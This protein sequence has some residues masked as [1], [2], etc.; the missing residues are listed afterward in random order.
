MMKTSRSLQ[1]WVLF[2]LLIIVPA[3]ASAHTINL[4]IEPKTGWQLWW[5]F[6]GTGYKHIL[7]LGLDHILFITCLFFIA[8]SHKQLIAYSLIFTLA[9]SI[10]LGLAVIQFIPQQ[11][12]FVEP[13][14]ALSIVMMAL[15]AL[16]PQ[17]VGLVPRAALIFMFGLLHGL[18]FAGAL[19][20]VGIPENAVGLSLF[21][22]NL[23]VEGGQITV[24]LLL[25]LS[26]R[27]PF[28][29]KPWYQRRVS[30]PVLI[31][32]ACTALY[33]TIERL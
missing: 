10:T 18:G 25:Y 32:I 22:F 13:L 33:W 4:D 6:L 16:R 1:Q 24:L 20:E 7:P 21:A 2:S 23:G 17:T 28:G 3:I 12:P 8:K 11:L 27:L 30:F 14:I 5:Q 26:L 31:G 29:T 15:S 19:S 9:H